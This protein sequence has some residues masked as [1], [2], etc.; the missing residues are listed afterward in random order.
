MY[1]LV[2]GETR[3]SDAALISGFVYLFLPYRFTDLFSRGDLGEFAAFAIL[4]FALWGYR[5][6]GRNK[7][8][9]RSLV[10]TLTAIVHGAVWFFHPLIGVLFTG[11]VIL[12]QLAQ[13]FGAENSKQGRALA[14]YGSCVLLLG[15]L[16]AIVYL[17]PAILE[18]PLIHLENLR[19]FCTPTTKYLVGWTALISPGFFSVGWPTLLGAAVLVV[20]SLFPPTRR[21]LIA[22]VPLW[23]LTLSA[24]AFVSMSLVTNVWFSRYFW[25]AS[26]FGMYLLYPFRLLGFAGL[27]SA[28]A[29]GLVWTALVPATWRDA[30]WL[31]AVALS[32]VIALSNQSYN[33]P[34]YVVAPTS[35][36]MIP[37]VIR[38]NG[39]VTT[40]VSDEFLPATVPQAPTLNQGRL[41]LVSMDPSGISID[42]G[43]G[44]VG[45]SA[46]VK[47]RRFGPL[48]YRIEAQARLP[49][50]FDL[51]VFYYPGWTVETVRGPGKVSQSPSPKGFIRLSLPV[52][53]DYYLT[54]NFGST[55]LRDASALISSLAFLLS[56]PLL[57]CLSRW[58][59]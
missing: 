28:I 44:A 47:V 37:A 22:G 7:V 14:L 59:F 51:N 6:L 12:L 36:Q 35:E 11:L 26:P 31:G 42:G 19:K 30:G 40:V 5:A 43:T 38:F 25:E 24:L 45:N 1:G 29:I 41:G 48:S 50:S 39:L 53:G 34:V 21:R 49:G 18:R 2:Y 33:N 54:E 16:M 58:V 4:P 3:R 56:Y 17:A 8:G 57:W 27:F 9:R 46:R 13:L 20:A 15:T 10:G 52:P 23:L 32:F 55:P